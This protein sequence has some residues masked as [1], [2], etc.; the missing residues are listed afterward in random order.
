[1]LG[2]SLEVSLELLRSKIIE[3]YLLSLY[4]AKTPN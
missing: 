3:T 2:L 1:M 4:G